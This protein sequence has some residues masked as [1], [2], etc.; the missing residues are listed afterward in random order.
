M[1]QLAQTSKK[2]YFC[3]KKKYRKENIE[4]Y[5][6]QLFYDVRKSTIYVRKTTCVMY[7]YAKCVCVQ[8]IEY[9]YKFSFHDIQL[10]KIKY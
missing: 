10:T 7:K 5:L 8:R 4:K 9:V 1:V 3:I 6:K 2:L